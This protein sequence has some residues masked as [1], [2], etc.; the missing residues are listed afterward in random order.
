MFRTVLILH[1]LI[2]GI[3]GLFFYL[4][5]ASAAAL[6][7]WTLP[8]LAAR[9]VGSLLIG[10]A[11]CT[12]LTALSKANAP[13]AG[14]TFIGIGDGLIALTGALYAIENGLTGPMVIW[15]L[16]FVG[17]ALV[18]ILLSLSQQPPEN[19]N[20]TPTS[21]LIRPY[22]TLHM[23]VVAVVGTVMYVLP[24]QAQ[25]IWPWMMSLVNVRLIGGFFVGA[26]FYSFWCRR[27]AAWE[28]LQP[29]VAFYAFFATL[30]LI[31]SFIHFNLF[32]PTRLITWIFV[33]LYA[34]VGGGAWYFLWMHRWRITHGALQ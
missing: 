5:P 4:A 33:A 6:W 16:V 17:A 28:T 11:V 24:A 8:P 25:P 23:I 21:R 18:L 7:P 31:A 32:N 1:M 13:V 22:F 30:A 20:L 34:F 2:A 15:L 12:A 19:A 29:T 27:Q 9:F 3:A 26:A 10:G 14:I